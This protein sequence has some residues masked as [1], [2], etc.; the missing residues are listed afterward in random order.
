MVIQE[1]ELPY[2]IEMWDDHDTRIEALIA[3]VADHAV[4]RAAFAEAVRRQ[5]GRLIVLRQKSRVLADDG[6]GPGF[7]KSHRGSMECLEPGAEPQ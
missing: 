4:A 7:T 3:L 5:P 6:V 2:R 1:Q